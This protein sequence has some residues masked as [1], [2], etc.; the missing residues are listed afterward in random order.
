MTRSQLQPGASSDHYHDTIG[1]DLA[2]ALQLLGPEVVQF[3]TAAGGNHRTA[4]LIP[5]GTV[6]VKVF[7]LIDGL[8]LNPLTADANITIGIEAD[9]ESTSIDLVIYDP[10]HFTRNSAT[11]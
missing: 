11:L 3:T 10:S 8:T 6:V 9:D 4:L 2:I 7:A 5:A 1:V